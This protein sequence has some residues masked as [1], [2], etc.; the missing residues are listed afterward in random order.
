[1]LEK[2]L[3]QQ[4]QK[5]ADHEKEYQKGQQAIKVYQYAQPIADTLAQD[6]LTLHRK[7]P[8]ASLHNT[9]F[10]FS[11]PHN[12]LITPIVNAKQD[13]VGV[14][15]ISLNTEGQKESK[16]VLENRSMIDT[17][18]RVAMVRQGHNLCRIYIAEGVETAASLLSV[19]P[20]EFTVVASL[21]ITELAKSIPY[22]QACFYAYTEVVWL[23]DNDKLPDECHDVGLRQAAKSA[24]DDFEQAKV[25]FHEAGFNEGENLFILTPATP[26]Q[27]WNDVLSGAK[28]G[29]SLRRAFEQSQEPYQLN[30]SVELH[31]SI[32]Y[33]EE[34]EKT[35]QETV[36][37]SLPT[38]A[39]IMAMEELSFLIEIDQCSV[40][41]LEN[42][43]Q[44]LAIL[45]AAK[46]SNL[47]Q[48]TDANR[49]LAWIE[50]TL[51]NIENMQGF[52]W[53]NTAEYQN[54]DNG[55]LD[56]LTAKK[57]RWLSLLDL[58]SEE[59]GTAYNS[60]SDSTPTET[61][62]KTGTAFLEYFSHFAD[63]DKEIFKEKK[64]S[65][66]DVMELIQNIQQKQLDPLKRAIKKQEV[67]QLEDHINSF[68]KNIPMVQERIKHL[69]ESITRNQNA[70]IQEK[71]QRFNKMSQHYLSSFKKE[72][73]S[74][75]KLLF[76]CG[77]QGCYNNLSRFRAAKPLI[78]D[79][80]P[81]NSLN[82]SDLKH[83]DFL[84]EDEPE[85]SDT[86][87]EL[88]H[89]ILVKS[90]LDQEI[91]QRQKKYPYHK[92]S[93][94]LYTQCVTT[95][96]Y[97]LA[98]HMHQSFKVRIP[99]EDKGLAYQEFDG[100]AKR[101]FSTSDID[102]G[103]EKY[104]EQYVVIERKSNDETGQK[105]LQ[106]SFTQNK[107]NAK[108]HFFKKGIP[109]QSTS[110]ATSKDWPVFTEQ[111]ILLES[112]SKLVAI[113]ASDWYSSDAKRACRQLM[114][115]AK[116]ILAEA[117]NT[118]NIELIFNNRKH[119][120]SEPS[121]HNFFNQKY[122]QRVQLR[123]SNNQRGN[124][125]NVVKGLHQFYSHWA[126]TKFRCFYLQQGDILPGNAKQLESRLKILPPHVSHLLLPYSALQ[127]LSVPHCMAIQ[128]RFP[129]AAHVIVINETK[130][131]ELPLA[132]IL[133][134]E[135]REPLYHN[136][137]LLNFI[138]HWMLA[139]C[140]TASISPGKRPPFKLF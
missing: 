60:G 102:S 138:Q 132:K 118:R 46:L 28:D 7:I 75:S 65:R 114:T 137:D 96:A 16:K 31:R 91:A 59:V 9:S 42:I 30:H 33:A 2:K 81:S 53:H 61:L 12:A 128:Q 69:L 18:G 37:A 19:I 52:V 129:D 113:E 23:A 123:A 66:H 1:M 84:E 58:A 13:I 103:K 116:A 97:K 140:E 134:F 50:K 112:N 27:D 122:L 40:Q 32:Q 73:G 63:R 5:L 83:I 117:V 38:R 44:A 20:E 62:L 35:I 55:V 127:Y 78:Y 136:P 88:A 87:R 115:T 11:Q 3:K 133:E 80:G 54:L 98:I 8:L 56:Q 47:R 79:L 51:I 139:C 95:Y 92:I 106:R 120:L 24:K 21:G 131:L 36:D 22:I 89:D 108:H 4:A 34:E 64:Y 29:E 26:G 67:K 90:G 82:C 49:E 57:N 71:L 25:L 125:E 109:S 135:K 86:V 104:T 110:G 41:L 93:H 94:S 121:R 105:E 17:F 70:R 10:Q 74:M 14:Q 100:I 85:V 43:A 130:T 77:L 101:R 68:Q 72:D 6:Y 48:L 107:I 15:F 39:S 76:N 111:D 45:S 119:S 99:Q 126:S 124:E